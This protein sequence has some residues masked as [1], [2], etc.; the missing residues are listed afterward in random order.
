[1]RTSWFSLLKS[2]LVKLDRMDRPSHVINCHKAGCSERTHR[3]F[4][5]K[6]IASITSI[7]GKH[8]IVSL[9]TWYAFE[10]DDG[11]SRLT[12]Y[13][14]DHHS[15]RRS[16]Y[17]SICCICWSDS[18]EYVVWKDG[19]IE[20]RHAVTKTS[21]WSHRF[22]SKTISCLNSVGLMHN[23]LNIDFDRCSFWSP[24][25]SI[26]L[27]YS[28]WMCIILVW[29]SVLFSWWRRQSQI[30]YLILLSH[31]THGFNLHLKL[32]GLVSWKKFEK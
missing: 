22:L 16:I 20:T 15:S 5:S 2:L 32:I 4:F 26:D 17:V 24:H 7:S 29:I 9:N 11:S 12:H 10:K 23:P 18:N 3:K 6:E 31:C 8:I 21:K 13:S 14:I 30:V 27:S 28:W 25:I 1:M 19:P